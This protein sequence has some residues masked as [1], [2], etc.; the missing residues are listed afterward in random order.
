MNKSFVIFGPAHGGKSTLAGYLI[1]ASRSSSEVERS[2]HSIQDQLG[3]KY[4]PSQRF[5]YL[6]DRHTDERDRDKKPLSDKLGTSLYTHVESIEM[7]GVGQIA[8]IDTPGAEH[9]F[10]ERLKGIYYGDIGVF[11][12]ELSK[13]IQPARLSV[14]I[15]DFLTPLFTWLKF[16]RSQENVIVLFS[17]M[18]ESRYSEEEYSRGCEILKMLIGTDSVEPIPIAIHVDRGV[19]DNVLTRSKELDWYCGPIF[20]ESIKTKLANEN[21]EQIAS[22]FFMHVAGIFDVQHVGQVAHGKL[23]EG[24]IRVGDNIKIAP[25]NYR[26][27]EYREITARVE[28]LRVSKDEAKE[29][30]VAGDIATVKLSDIRLSGRRCKEDEFDVVPTTII[31]PLANN[32]SSGRLLQFKLNDAVDVDRFSFLDTVRVTWFG[33]LISCSVVYKRVVKGTCLLTLELENQ[34]AALPV[35][36]NRGPLKFTQFLLVSNSERFVPAELLGIGNAKQVRAVLPPGLDPTSF[37]GL[38]DSKVEDD[39]I[40]FPCRRIVKPIVNQ[41]RAFYRRHELESKS[42]LEDIFIEFAENYEP[43]K[44]E[45]LLGVS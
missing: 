12:I 22:S 15:R 27:K 4:E 37:F 36:E 8:V 43:I 5:A 31:V 41:I 44:Y 13:L 26:N 3:S 7:D 10:K 28:G 21:T 17:K 23:L 39:Y 1:A 6:V 20:Y 40:V 9:Q 35:K 2:L 42:L 38:M 24:C 18:D 45:K 11:L 34:V 29:V 33:K 19:D 16:G 14:D 30:V 25:V 32:L